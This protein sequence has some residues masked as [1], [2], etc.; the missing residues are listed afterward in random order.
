M[1]RV[2][3]VN[4]AHC[5]M[6][7]APAAPAKETEIGLLHEHCVPYYERNN[8]RSQDHQNTAFKPVTAHAAAT[9]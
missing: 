6:D 2:T 4:C 8:K 1:S 9:I 7:I 5:R 3:A